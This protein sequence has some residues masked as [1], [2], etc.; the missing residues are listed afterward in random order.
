[1]KPIITYPD[2]GCSQSELTVNLNLA[3]G[4][5][6]RKKSA[7]KVAIP[8]RETNLKFS[9]RFEQAVQILLALVKS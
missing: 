7:G 6:P 9:M 2:I 8:G 4:R 3:T 1:M 5:M